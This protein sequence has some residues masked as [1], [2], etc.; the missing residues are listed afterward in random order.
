MKERLF[1]AQAELE[2]T[3]VIGKAS[4]GL[5]TVTMKG[6]GEITRLVLDQQAI[7]D[8]DAE[9]I[10]SLVLAAIRDAA[11][12]LKTVATAKLTGVGQLF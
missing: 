2:E 10:A 8:G 5:A 4:G 6:T 9:S 1:M 3:E 7:D 11:D 12:V